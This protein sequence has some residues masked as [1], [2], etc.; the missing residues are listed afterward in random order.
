MKLEDDG[1]ESE[2]E[3]DL[4]KQ[5]TLD[6][7]TSDLDSDWAVV[8]DD[9]AHSRAHKRFAEPISCDEGSHHA[10]GVHGSLARNIVP[11]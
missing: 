8:I 3:N 11:A 9:L 4:Q 1:D 6:E 2:K 10:S 7:G 5:T